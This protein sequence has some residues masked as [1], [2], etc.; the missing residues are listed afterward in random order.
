MCPTCRMLL[1]PFSPLLHS[2]K[3]RIHCNPSTFVTS[4]V[5]ASLSSQNSWYGAATGGGVPVQASD[6]AVKSLGCCRVGDG[7]CVTWLNDVPSKGLN[8]ITLAAVNLPCTAHLSS[9]RKFS[10]ESG[11]VEISERFFRLCRCCVRCSVSV[12]EERF[13]YQEMQEDKFL[14]ASQ[15]SF[16]FGHKNTKRFYV[17]RGATA[18]YAVKLN[19][20]NWGRLKGKKS[21]RKHCAI[22]RSGLE[23]VE[24]CS[25]SYLYAPC[26]PMGSV[27]CLYDS[28]SC[29][30][31]TRSSWIAK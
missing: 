10:F 4:P 12:T 9:R 18:F 26:S 11:N 25:I 14:E 30:A 17:K 24:K 31:R 2:G 19:C 5:T 22:Q 13:I 1:G 27:R 7:K 15:L 28:D 29:Y 16:P 8:A 21:K 23:S 6:N 3:G 20:R